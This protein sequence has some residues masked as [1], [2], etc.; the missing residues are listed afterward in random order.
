MCSYKKCVLFNID[1][2]SPIEIITID[3]ESDEETFVDDKSFK[4]ECIITKSEPGYSEIINFD[5]FEI[6]KETPELPEEDEETEDPLLKRLKLQNEYL[7]KLVQLNQSQNPSAVT[8]SISN[9]SYFHEFNHPSTNWLKNACKK[10]KLIYHQNAYQLWANFDIIY[11]TENTKP[12]QIFAMDNGK[13]SGFRALSFVISGQEN[14]KVKNIIYKYFLENFKNLGFFGGINFSTLTIDSEIINETIFAEYLTP[15][16]WEII[17]KMLECRIGIFIGEKLVKYGNWNSNKN[18]NN[19]D[20][21]IITL[22]FQIV[23]ENYCV[24]KSVIN[25]K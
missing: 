15:E 2:F 20:D 3:D 11:I 14:Q 17:A 13:F 16:L 10:L 19:E 7:A 23:G 25:Q 8:S 4:E 22:L 9:V 24:V 21:E 6:D 1:Y 12:N 18:K 5:P